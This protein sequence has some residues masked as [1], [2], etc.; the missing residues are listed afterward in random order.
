MGRIYVGLRGKSWRTSR[1]SKV[2]SMFTAGEQAR[3]SWT[4]AGSWGWGA[5]EGGS[6]L[7]AELCLHLGPPRTETL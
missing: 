7:G 4:P 5:G 2:R 6:K 1:L 3:G